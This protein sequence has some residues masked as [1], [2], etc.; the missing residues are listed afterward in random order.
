MHKA[1]FAIA[2]ITGLIGTAAA[3]PRNVCGD[4]K[5][6]SSGGGE[7]AE[8]AKAAE[9]ALCSG[10][11]DPDTIW[12]L[13]VAE[14]TDTERAALV[15]YG[16]LNGGG[17][18]SSELNSIGVLIGVALLDT[19]Q[20][21]LDKLDPDLRNGRMK[22]A[23]DKLDK[24]KKKRAELEADKRWK[25]ILAAYAAGNKAW[26]D[27]TKA[28][29]DELAKARELHEAA[30]TADTANGCTAKA[31]A[32]IAPLLAAARPDSVDK[33]RDTLEGY[34]VSPAYRALTECAVAEK[35]KGTITGLTSQP[36][37]DGSKTSN[38]RIDS[39]PGPRAAGIKAANEAIAKILKED[40]QFPLHSA[41]TG[42]SWGNGQQMLMMNSQFPYQTDA[43]VA[44][45]KPNKDGKVVVSFKTETRDQPTFA[46]KDTKQIQRILNT[47]NI[48]YVQDCK[49]TGVVK[50]KNT[51]LPIAVGAP[52]AA[53]LK[54]GTFVTYVW[55]GGPYDKA[56]TVEDGS[57]IFK[58]EGPKKKKLTGWGGFA[59]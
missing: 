20:F 6:A 51:P 5:A 30:R 23:F 15:G 24:W 55:L 34:V 40:S 18:G 12:S 21:A 11:D 16:L 13:D 26:F 28:H 10:I 17:F 43:T 8:R 53:G 22:Q 25:Q 1:S 27:A 50:L 52:F 48:E 7:T 58:W 29:Q 4:L 49:Q 32:L 37:Y 46:C 14:P 35:L 47:G 42:P 59:W 33:L 44:S 31:Y 2:T 39:I 57:I 41:G 38:F 36:G 19:D 9:K 3:G 45:V 56:P 54:P